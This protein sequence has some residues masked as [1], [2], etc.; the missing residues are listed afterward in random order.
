MSKTLTSSGQEYIF[1]SKYKLK[2][3]LGSGSFGDIYLAVDISDGEEVAVKL[4][5]VYVRVFFLVILPKSQKSSLN[6]TH[7]AKSS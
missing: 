2:R 7:S 1:G 5:P 4:E 3:K 6:F